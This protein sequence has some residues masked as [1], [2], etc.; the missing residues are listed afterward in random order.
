MEAVNGLDKHKE[1]F[2]RSRYKC[3]YV[4]QTLKYDSD[5][6]AAGGHREGRIA[7]E[8]ICLLKKVDNAS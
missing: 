1:D 7:R 5:E 8:S 2:C 3:A 4:I 6:W